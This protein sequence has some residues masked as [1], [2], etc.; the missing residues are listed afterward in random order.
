MP[1]EA[2][3]C[4]S[5]AASI[6]LRRSSSAAS[7]AF[8]RSALFSR[9]SC[10]S[11]FLASRLCWRFSFLCFETLGERILPGIQLLLKLLLP[12]SSCTRASSAFASAL[13][14]RA[15]SRMVMTVSAIT[16]AA[17]T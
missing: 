2:A 8:A 12:S 6:W 3:E 13:L 15:K 10:K 11:S 1:D 7:R 4:L 14:M 16:A 9:D 17:S 5:A